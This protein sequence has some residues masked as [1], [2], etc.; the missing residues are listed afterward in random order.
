MR[1]L[2][3]VDACAKRW[4]SGISLARRISHGLSRA[5]PIVRVFMHCAVTYGPPSEA[6][7][8]LII[9]QLPVVLPHAYLRI[10]YRILQLSFLAPA[11]CASHVP[12]P[13]PPLGNG[14]VNGSTSSR[15]LYNIAVVFEFVFAFAR[16][17]RLRSNGS[18]CASVAMRE[19][20]LYPPIVGGHRS[21]LACRPANA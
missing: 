3:S 4:L 19:S 6:L 18:F 16:W 15:Y 17:L 9:L 12:P 8:V 1:A 13:S 5:T 10:P 11:P 7:S 21:Q 2:R 20:G 14:D